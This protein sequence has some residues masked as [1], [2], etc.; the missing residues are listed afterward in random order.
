MN[1]IDMSFKRSG[2]EVELQ[3]SILFE[4]A[5][6]IAM[7]TYPKIKDKLDKPAY[8]WDQLRESLSDS[9]EK[10]L[11]YCQEHNTWKMLLQILHSQDFDSL[12]SFLTYISNL[13]DQQ[14]KYL[15]LPFLEESHQKLRYLASQGDM[16]AMDQMILACKHHLFFP[17]M[18]HFLSE[19]DLSELRGHLIAVM[20][21][22]YAEVVEKDSEVITNLLKRDYAE[23]QK[24]LEKTPYEKVVEWAVGEEYKPE[25]NISKV[26]LIPHKIYRPWTIQANLEGTKIFYYP[27][28]QNSLS[29][30]DE[31]ESLALLY[32]ALGDEKRL[33]IMKL[34]Y[35]KERSLK[36]ITEI[37]AIGKTTVHHHLAILKSAHIVKVKES[38]YTLIHHSLNRL[39]PML[40][41]YLRKG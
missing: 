1:F 39:E 34:L 18:I 31:V 25:P 36:E 32:K 14:L 13:T 21:G 40:M 23:K 4:C 24:M 20:E 3:Y 28:S 9:L 29:D 10:E 7:I 2:Y 19:V 17:Q 16:D 41:D 5:L 30:D 27:I 26:L 15:S 35:E 11:Q 37:L 12:S 22:W 8:Y 33:K 6:G 38:T